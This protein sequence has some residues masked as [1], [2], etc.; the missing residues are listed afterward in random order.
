M[1]AEMPSHVFWRSVVIPQTAFESGS[2]LGP[3]A[4]AIREMAWELSEVA[5]RVELYELDHYLVPPSSEQVRDY[6]ENKRRHLVGEVFQ[7]SQFVVLGFLPD[8]T[9]RLSARHIHDWASALNALQILI[10]RWPRHPGHFNGLQQLSRRTSENVLA[11][12][13]QDAAVHYCQR[14]YKWSERAAIVPWV[15]PS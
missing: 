3:Y 8:C 15:W 9:V 1:H 2:N 7:S 6:C 13:E 10:L 14:F 11:S 12:F 4:A 5:F